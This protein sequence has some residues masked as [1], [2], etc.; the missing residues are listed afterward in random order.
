MH[1]AQAKGDGD[2]PRPPSTAC[3]SGGSARVCRNPTSET[4]FT[5]RLLTP[6]T[7][8]LRGASLCQFFWNRRGDKRCAAQYQTCTAALLRPQVDGA[9]RR[10]CWRQ[11][12]ACSIFGMRCGP[13]DVCCCGHIR[14]KNGA[15]A[16]GILQIVAGVMFGLV[17]LKQGLQQANNISVY[18]YAVSAYWIFEAFTGFLVIMGVLCQKPNLII[19]G[20]A[21]KLL[22]VLVPV[23]VF[24]ASIVVMCLSARISHYAAENLTVDDTEMF[25]KNFT[26]LVL[27]VGFLLMSLSLL[28]FVFLVSC[29]TV[30]W[31]CRTHIDNVVHI[32]INNEIPLKNVENC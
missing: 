15:I 26:Y 8:L 16:I 21:L 20:I 18:F 23:V 28:A 11:L 2:G 30:L 10:R 3:K 17:F 14:I 12:I 27:I 19:P 6:I 5:R 13:S 25:V 22:E 1:D 29:L 4:V 24:L 9:I 31:K 7:L 32:V